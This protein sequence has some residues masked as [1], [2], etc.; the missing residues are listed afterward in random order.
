MLAQGRR[1]TTVSTR[2]S[3]SCRRGPRNDGHILPRSGGATRPDVDD[4]VVHPSKAGYLEARRNQNLSLPARSIDPDFPTPRRS[5]P[6]RSPSVGP[7][8]VLF[9][10]TI[11]T[12]QRASRSTVRVIE[13]TIILCSGPRRADP[14]TRRAAPDDVAISASTGSAQTSLVMTG[15]VGN[16]SRHRVSACSRARLAAPSAVPDEPGIVSKSAGGSGVHADRAVRG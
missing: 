7:E 13:P 1:N 12:G 14:T 15:T 2:V 16:S 5:P 3:C 8:V 9:R 10:L 11:A 6:V 4:L